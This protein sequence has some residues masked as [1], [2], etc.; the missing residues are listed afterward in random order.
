MELAQRVIRIEDELKGEARR[1]AQIRPAVRQVRADKDEVRRLDILH[2]IADETLALPLG[3][4]GQF[5]FRMEVPLV[6]PAGQFQP[7]A[8][9][10][11]PD[12]IGEIVGPCEEAKRFPRLQTDLFKRKRHIEICLSE[13]HIIRRNVT[14]YETKTLFFGWIGVVAPTAFCLTLAA[15]LSPGWLRTQGHRRRFPPTMSPSGGSATGAGSAFRNLIHA[16]LCG[17]RECYEFVPT[18]N[19]QPICRYLRNLELRSHRPRRGEDLHGRVA[20]QILAQVAR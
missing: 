4:Q 2:V 10:P 11:T 9:R 13:Y 1:R 17:G 18:A 8:V 15:L 12:D 16:P 14:Y 20:K 5:V 6:S 7:R 3:D 19:R